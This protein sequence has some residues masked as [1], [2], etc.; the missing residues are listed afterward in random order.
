MRSGRLILTATVVAAALSG[1]A[2]AVANA[3]GLATVPPSQLGGGL[4]VTPNPIDRSGNLVITGNVGGG[5]QF[6]GAVPYRSTSDFWGGLGS[7]SL[8]SFLRRSYVPSNRQLYT[9][10][11]Q[12]Y[13]S[14]SRTV[15]TLRPDNLAADR[16]ST[17]N[18]ETRVNRGAA[19]PLQSESSQDSLLS[20]ELSKFSSP[21]VAPGTGLETGNITLPGVGTSSDIGE[22]ADVALQRFGVSRLPK[23]T[24]PDGLSVEG[25]SRSAFSAEQ[26]RAESE[27]AQFREELR[28]VPPEGVLRR[29]L[30]GAEQMPGVGQEGRNGAEDSA[31]WGPRRDDGLVQLPQREGTAEIAMLP[32]E[33]ARVGDGRV[34]GLPEPTEQTGG[35]ERSGL[36]A[37]ADE[38]AARA[39]SSAYERSRAAITDFG[40]GIDLTS[41]SYG[42]AD[43]LE[44]VRPRGKA[45]VNNQYRDQAR[46][47]LG[48]YHTVAS[49]S[50]A[51]FDEHI[52]AADGYL[53]LGEYYRAA[54][55][56]RLALV[57][58]RGDP[59]AQAGR[60]HAL[61]AAG[62]YISSALFAWLAILRRSFSTIDKDDVESRI[63][64]A[65][66]WRNTSDVGELHFLLAY[67]YHQMGRGELAKAAIE[68][69]YEKMPEVPAVIMLKSAVESAPNPGTSPT[70]AGQP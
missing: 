15:T 1:D 60:G 22:S 25:L 23:R 44:D 45:G 40:R 16:F 8:D 67:V 66:Q 32:E 48:P 69:A 21:R 12:P 9:Q 5:R 38:A 27:L 20:T 64:D 62:E 63:V 24:V 68:K 41:Q 34:V 14:P 29:E 6:Q 11:Y 59:M 46:E 2:L 52:R 35:Q 18:A 50:K 31:I 36:Q 56:Y 7:A 28:Q 26:F 54:D 19:V 42:E 30:A 13:Y 3:A 51:K 43:P 17:Y 37:E 4:V 65:E 55:S 57:Y 33:L 49:Y 39:S 53:G 58:E 70:N 47:I 61:F 10:T